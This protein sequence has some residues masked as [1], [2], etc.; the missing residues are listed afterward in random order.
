MLGTRVLV[1]KGVLCSYP[2][3]RG[4]Q[5]YHQWRVWLSVCHL[6]LVLGIH[7]GSTLLFRSRF[8]SGS[9]A[10][11]NR[12]HDKGSPCQTPLETWKGELTTPF[13]ITL[14]LADLYRDFTVWMNH[15]TFLNFSTGSHGIFYHILCSDLELQWDHLSGYFS[16]VDHHS[17]QLHPVKNVSIRY[18]SGLVGVYCQKW[19]C[20]TQLSYINSSDI[21]MYW[22]ILHMQK[23]LW[24]MHIYL[25]ILNML[26]DS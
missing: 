9:I 8:A 17:C 13:I 22:H 21:Q 20:R 24:S 11:L 18:E 10:R 6:T 4:R 14:V 5:L 7:I 23:H 2:S 12:K 1:W 19:I 16:I 15:F 25:N 3:Y 26:K